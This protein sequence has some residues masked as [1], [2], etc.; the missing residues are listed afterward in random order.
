MCTLGTESFDSI[1]SVTTTSEH[2]LTQSDKD[3]LELQTATEL[4]LSQDIMRKIS[5]LLK[6]Q[7]TKKSVITISSPASKSGN[8]TNI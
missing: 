6:E 5:T 1:H 8:E 4:V 2:L 3:L 7:E